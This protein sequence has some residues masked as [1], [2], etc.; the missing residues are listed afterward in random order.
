MDT[1][2]HNIYPVYDAVEKRKEKEQ[3]LRQRSC[4]IWLTGLS[5]AGKS[6]I[7][8][9]LEA[10]LTKRGFF[11]QILDGDNIRNGINNNLGFSEADRKE[12]IRRISEVAKL[13]MHSG[14]I[15]ICSFISPTRE[16]R[17]MARNII[18]DTDFVEV[19]VN[20]PIEICEQRDIKGLYKKA[21]EG[22]IPDF[23]GVSSPYEVPLNPEVEIKTEGL[24]IQQSVMY[25]LDYLIPRIT[26]TK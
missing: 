8:L 24:S 22:K 11:S 14:V 17:T 15:T 21:R 10:E 5:G 12:N 26:Y 20:T 6:T 7:G 19:Y 2:V 13:L 16:I 25:L 3:L 1:N 4:V 18:G 9:G 23:T